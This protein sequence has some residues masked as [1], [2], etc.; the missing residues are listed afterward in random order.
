[1]RLLLIFLATLT[2]LATWFSANAPASDAICFDGNN[3]FATQAPSGWVADFD[4]AKEFGLCVIYYVRGTTFDSSPAVIYP[5]LVTTK[6]NGKAA[7]DDNI[8]LNTGRLKKRKPT[9][10]VE[11]KK[12]IKNKHGLSFEIRY[13][14]EGPPPQE[15]EAVAYHAGKNAVLLSVF[16]TRS[17]KAFDSHKGKL[18]EF[19]EKIRQVSKDELKK[20]Q[21]KKK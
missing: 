12:P 11:S 4:K 18:N 14:I 8:A 3:S 7:V 19:V 16:S 9:V 10:K 6:L 17:K 1:M 5:N 13:F 20:H 21:K 2:F 15:F